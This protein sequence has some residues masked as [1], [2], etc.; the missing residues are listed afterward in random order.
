MFT[1][2]SKFFFG[3]SAASLAAAVVYATVSGG[4]LLGGLSLGWYGGV[5]DHLGFAVLLGLGVGMLVLGVVAVWVRDADAEEMAALVGTPERVPQAVPP[6]RPS[7]WGAVTAFAV[8]SLIVGATVSPLFL[9]VGFGLLAVVVIEWAVLAWT[10]RATGDAEANATLR[11]RLMLP[12]EVPLFGSIGILV[13]ALGVSRVLLAV[14]QMTA[15]VIASLV[16][17][18]AFALAIAFAY[19][20]GWF[21]RNAVSGLI[22]GFAG[23]V[24]VGGIV[25]AAVGP[26]EFHDYSEDHRTE[27]EAEDGGVGGTAPG[28]GEE[29]PSDGTRRPTSGEGS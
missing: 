27:I 18:V 25:G 4:G 16:A 10:D 19:R 23:L 11:D 9:A 29:D 1:W 28:P 20:P 7:Y 14:S 13:F 3:L 22:A 15:V 21:T 12:I 5:G 24:I 8:A 2:G 6:S 17:S 26:R